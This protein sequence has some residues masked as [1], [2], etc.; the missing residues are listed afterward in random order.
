MSIMKKI[1]KYLPHI[2][3]GILFYLDQGTKVEVD[4]NLKIS[5]QDR[6]GY[7]SYV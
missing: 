1:N 2:K 3:G 6:D 7:K 4:S 5:S